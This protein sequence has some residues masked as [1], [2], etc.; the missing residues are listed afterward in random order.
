MTDPVFTRRAD[1]LAWTRQRLRFPDPHPMAQLRALE[2][3]K[4]VTL[5]HTHLEEE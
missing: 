3:I 2:D 1:L 4:R 5:A